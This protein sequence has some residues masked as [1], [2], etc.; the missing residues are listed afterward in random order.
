MNVT[1]KGLQSV[2]WSPYFHGHN[3]G[4]S[5][6]VYYLVHGNFGG[7]LKLLLVLLS[8]LH[9]LQIL[10]FF[11]HLVMLM[12]HRNRNISCYFLLRH[13]HCTCDKILSSL[14]HIFFHCWIGGIFKV[15]KV[16]SSRWILG[17]ESSSGKIF[18]SDIL[19]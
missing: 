12:F 11:G 2:L 7:N 10:I 13:S 8:V 9:K 6:K 16:V 5:P 15:I 4:V 17:A 1:E 3:F 14:L 18:T 19:F